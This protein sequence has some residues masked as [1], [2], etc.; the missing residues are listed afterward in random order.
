[1]GAITLK[2]KQPEIKK[3]VDKPSQE[4]YRRTTDTQSC[5]QSEPA[6]LTTAW[7]RSETLSHDLH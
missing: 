6:K 4:W 1:M 2:I 7:L 5:N 3:L